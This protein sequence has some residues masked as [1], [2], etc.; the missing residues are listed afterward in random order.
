MDPKNVLERGYSIT[1]L[2]GKAVKSVA[3]VSAND[4]LETILKDGKLESEVRSYP[5]PKE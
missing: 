1:R 4:I 2:K 3:E 5:S